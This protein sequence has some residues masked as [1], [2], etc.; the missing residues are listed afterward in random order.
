MIPIGNGNLFVEPIYLQAQSSRLPELKRVVVVNGN[1]IAMEPTLQRAIEVV[2]GRAAP[3]LPVTDPN[4]TPPT[5]S[6]TPG[7]TPSASP[8]PSAAT[9]TTAAGL[10]GTVPELAREADAAYQR[11]QAA[12]QQ[13]DFATYGTEIQRVEELIQEIVRLTGENP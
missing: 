4:A 7:T 2:F 9:P 1:D 12:L 8:T 11:A 3:S 10:P 6:A 5:G 13:G